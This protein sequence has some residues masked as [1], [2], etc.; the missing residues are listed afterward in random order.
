MTTL[1]AH[2]LLQ[3]HGTV[4]RYIALDICQL[5]CTWEIET[6]A[7]IAMVELL[8]Y[9]SV[10]FATTSQANPPLCVSS[11]QAKQ[12]VRII[13]LL[14]DI[15]RP[16][17]RVYAYT[18]RVGDFDPP[19]HQPTRSFRIPLLFLSLQNSCHI[20]TCT[21]TCTQI[22]H[23]LQVSKL[24]VKPSSQLLDDQLLFLGQVSPPLLPLPPPLLHTA[25][26]LLQV[27]QLALQPFHQL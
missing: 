13:M 16:L 8:R 3:A 20:H 22:P 7:H 23:S 4:T 19:T 26:T 5:P 6:V 1:L 25:C 10:R 21:C 2:C 11:R 9:G 12:R 15:H 27:P 24:H 14:F 17:P 18:P